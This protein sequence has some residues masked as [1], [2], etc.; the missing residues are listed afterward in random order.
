MP[1]IVDKTAIFM[2]H[3]DRMSSKGDEFSLQRLTNNLVIDVIGS[4]MTGANFHAQDLENPGEFG[5]LLQEMF[6]SYASEQ[7]DLPWW[8]TPFTYITRRRLSQRMRATVKKAIRDA[9]AALPQAEK[10]PRKPASILDLVLRD[11]DALTPEIEESI[12]EQ[13]RPFLWAGQDTTSKFCRFYVT[14]LSFLSFFAS[15]LFKGFLMKGTVKIIFT[16]FFS[17]LSPSKTSTS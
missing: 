10:Q 12:C 2:E 14:L 5:Q 6:V 4:V 1:V 11:I 3:L 17:F 13:I 9:Y 16:L 7:L 15:H 8:F